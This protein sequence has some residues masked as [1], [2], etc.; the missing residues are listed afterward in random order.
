M[1]KAE[2]ITAF[3]DKA[4]ITKVEADVAFSAIFEIIAAELAKQE[5]VVI[6]GFGSFT[7]KVRAE[8]KGRNP[9]TGKEMTIPKAVVAHFKAAAQ[10][11]DIINK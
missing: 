7:S 2:F 9:S 3:A 10:L 6:P 4:G 11:K 1:N 8:R 5:K